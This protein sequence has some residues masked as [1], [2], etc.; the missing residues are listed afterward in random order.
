MERLKKV[1]SFFF[2]HKAT[3]GAGISPD[4][5]I[6]LG[7][8]P[9]PIFVSYASQPADQIYPIAKAMIT[10]YDAYKDSAPGAGGSPPTGRPRT[11]W[12]RCIPAP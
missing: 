10:G 11:G 9:Y 1:G 4:K 12:C 6:E 8:Y 3:C 2:P 7:N 5:P